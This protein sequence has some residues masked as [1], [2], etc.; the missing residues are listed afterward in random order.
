MDSEEIREGIEKFMPFSFKCVGGYSDQILE[1]ERRFI[2]C[3]PKSFLELIKLFKSMLNKK[4]GEL[5]DSKDRYELGVV[6]LTETGEI[7]GKL[8]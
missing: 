8:E 3:T 5:S 7:V 6:K 2:Y 4:Y 1:Q